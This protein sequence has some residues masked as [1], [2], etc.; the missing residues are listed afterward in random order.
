M[1]VAITVHDKMSELW[2]KG[3]VGRQLRY[4]V[5]ARFGMI[6][7]RSNINEP[8]KDGIVKFEFQQAY[9]SQRGIHQK[10]CG[11]WRIKILCLP[12]GMESLN[13]DDRGVSPGFSI[14]PK[15]I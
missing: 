12:I 3:V 8:E 2:Q 11:I 5:R 7:H 1:T 9:I 13:F 15:E 4:E 6:Y 14:L 10:N